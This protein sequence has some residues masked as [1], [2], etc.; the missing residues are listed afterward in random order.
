MD[1]GF[2]D[3]LH[4]DWDTFTALGLDRFIQQQV[5]ARL[6]NGSTVIDH[7]SLVRLLIPECGID[8]NMFCLSSPGYGKDLLLVGSAFL[9]E[10][11]AVIDYPQEQTT[12]SD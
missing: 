6:A 2:S 11:N 5:T 8:R 7:L 9:K 3:Y 10:C 12:L 1:T 4:L